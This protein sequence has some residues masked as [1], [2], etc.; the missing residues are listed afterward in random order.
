MNSFKARTK[1]VH[2]NLSQGCY[3]VKLHIINT[4]HLCYQISFIPNFGKIRFET[5]K[6]Y[7]RKSGSIN[8]KVTFS[9]LQ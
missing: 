6:I 7:L 2:K 1:V 9:D 4:L 3:K 5:Q 8:K